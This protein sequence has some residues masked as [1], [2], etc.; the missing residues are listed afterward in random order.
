MGTY[1]VGFIENGKFYYWSRETNSICAN[2]TYRRLKRM[3]LSPV[4]YKE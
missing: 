2:E 1:V 4:V 3:G